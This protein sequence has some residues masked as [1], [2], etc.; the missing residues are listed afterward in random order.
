M[1]CALVVLEDYLVRVFAGDMAVGEINTQPIQ[2]ALQF[3]KPMVRI[4][5]GVTRLCSRS[6]RLSKADMTI[7]LSSLSFAFN[8]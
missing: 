2:I 6:S 4:E 1:S 7:E 8:P 3:M 5:H